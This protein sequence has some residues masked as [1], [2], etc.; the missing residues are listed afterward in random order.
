VTG[1]F[2]KV[3]SFSGGEVVRH[4]EEKTE[5]GAW[6]S[7]G[8]IDTESYF[9]DFLTTGPL[10]ILNFPISRPDVLAFNSLSLKPL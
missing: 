5:P 9:C 4:L 6:L 2:V 10:P 8:K 1:H 3:L 7:L